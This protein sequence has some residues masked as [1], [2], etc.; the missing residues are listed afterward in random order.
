MKKVILA[1]SGGLDTT[2]CLQWLKDQGYEVVCFSADL[3]GEFSPADL[4]KRAIKGGASKIYIKDLR[5]E[6]A[7]NYILPALR[8][9]LIYED[10]YVLSTA[11]GRPLI[12]KHLVEVARKEKAKFVSH[13]S[14]GKGNDQLRFELTT[15]VLGPNLETIA[16][17]RVWDLTSRESEVSYAK[18]N[19]LPLKT[20]KERIYSVDKNIWGTSVEGGVLEEPEKEPPL[21]S[22]YSVKPLAKA[23]NKEVSLSIEFQKG[24]PVKLQGKKMDLVSL[25]EKLNKI[26]AKAGIG[27]TDLIEDRVVGIKSREIYEAPGAWILLKAHKELESLVLDGEIRQFK[28]LVACKYAQL[29]Y[30][31]LWFTNLREALAN[32]VNSTQKRVTGKISL[33]LYKGNITV[34]KRISKYSIYKKELATYGK[35]DSFN[36]NWAEGFIN[37]WSAPYKK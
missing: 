36:R 31:G 24:I 7:Y 2:C 22:Y 26:G 37:I 28:E 17:L 1:Y 8:A 30:Q 33:K 12:A 21:N 13:G 25:I 19:K 16:P 10:K 14:T 9:N 27:R 6:F 15:Q 34:A 11:L 23:P 29:V 5:K 35:K 32:F 4:R 18:K 20:T 3:G